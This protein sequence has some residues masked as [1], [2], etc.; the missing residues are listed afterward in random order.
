MFDGSLSESG[1]VEAPCWARLA[2]MLVTELPA[3]GLACGGLVDRCELLEPCVEALI[4]GCDVGR[5]DFGVLA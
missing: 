1:A 3:L 5:V 2:N 4:L